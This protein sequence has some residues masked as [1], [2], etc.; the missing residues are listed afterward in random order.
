MKIPLWTTILLSAMGALAA[1]SIGS[2]VLAGIATG[3]SSPAHEVFEAVALKEAAKGA[4]A[5]QRLDITPGRLSAPAASL[6]YLVTEAFGLERYQV[7]EM[8]GW[9]ESDVYTI[10][11]STGRPV[12]SQEIRAMLRELLESR[13]HLK[14]HREVRRMA[15]FAL[16]VDKGGLKMTPFSDGQPLVESQ[17]NDDEVTLPIGTTISDLVKHLNTRSGSLA[18]GRPVIDKTG[19]EGRYMIRLTFQVAVNR[20]AGAGTYSIDY[21]S[22]LRKEL[23]LRLEPLNAPVE[24]LVVDS[25]QKP[26]LD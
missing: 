24:F 14:T 9:M 16:V 4:R 7:G 15:V 23:G 6:R 3:Q 5:M 13:F 21:P 17:N 20:E 11:A 19:L 22:A 25:A 12:D 26:V 8:P 10:N 18:V 2:C 1:L